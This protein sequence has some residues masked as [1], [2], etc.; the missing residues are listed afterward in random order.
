LTG[1]WGLGDADPNRETGPLGEV[2]GVDL[3]QTLGRGLTLGL[4]VAEADTG[5][6]PAGAIPQGF[7]PVPF[8]ARA[9]DRDP[10][11]V[12]AGIEKETFNLSL[13]PKMLVWGSST[14][15][16]SPLNMNLRGCSTVMGGLGRP[17]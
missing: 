4:R 11:L 2:V 15:I 6:G 17:W 8:R 13:H 12:L 10:A 1:Q 16:P 14:L 7:D 9:R 5:P 3:A